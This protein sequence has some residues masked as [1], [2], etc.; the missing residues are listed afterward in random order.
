MATGE[1]DFC[2]KINNKISAEQPELQNTCLSMRPIGYPIARLPLSC[3]AAAM[4]ALSQSEHSVRCY[5]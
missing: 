5:R 3:G 4:A 1:C 2:G